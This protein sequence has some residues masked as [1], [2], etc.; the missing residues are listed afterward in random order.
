MQLGEETFRTRGFLTEKEQQSEFIN[1]FEFMGFENSL[2]ALLPQAVP[3]RSLWSQVHV[4]VELDNV[5]SIK[6][7]RVAVSRSIRM[8]LKGAKFFDKVEEAGLELSF[9]HLAGELN[10][11]ADE[12]SRRQSSHADW[13]LHPWLFQS[14]Q[15][16]LGLAPSIDLFASAH[17]TQVPR[18]FSYNFDHRA[19]AADA[20]L[21]GWN[22]LGT[23]YACPP[24]ILLGRVLLDPAQRVP[25][26]PPSWALGS[27][28]R[29]KIT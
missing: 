23:T 16:N 11:A 28:M 13:K 9:R 15:D 17:N 22:Q 19:V 3:D 24:P 12:L 14:T 26:R 5:T 29:L 6:Y 1:E 18:F 27:T 20:F 2:W 8:S 25:F 10:V 4:S 7:G 21:Y